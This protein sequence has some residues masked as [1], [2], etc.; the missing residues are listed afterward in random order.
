MHHLFIRC[1]FFL[2]H[3][4][5]ETVARCLFNFQIKVLFWRF[6]SQTNP[7]CSGSF[8]VFF[9]SFRE[10]KKQS[11]GCCFVNKHIHKNYAVSR[12]FRCH[13][14]LQWHAYT[15]NTIFLFNEKKKNN[16]QTRYT[17]VL[18]RV[19]QQQLLEICCREIAFLIRFVCMSCPLDIRCEQNCFGC[20]WPFIFIP[21]DA[22]C[23]FNCSTLTY[24]A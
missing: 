13:L 18:E 7:C 22:Y 15:Q 9:F 19:S 23:H 21:M 4:L 3:R 5:R 16:K 2:I 6:N 20:L 1:S 10:K 17:K 14:N 24:F 12:N 11:S 8:L